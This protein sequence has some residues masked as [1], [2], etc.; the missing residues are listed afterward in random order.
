M[1]KSHKSRGKTFKVYSPVV[2]T[3]IRSGYLYKSPP[4]KRFK[5]EKSWKNRYF[6]LFKV[7]SN[8][9]Q[10]KYFKSADEKE[11]PLGEIDLEQISLL[12]VNPVQHQRWEWIQKNFMCSP[13]C[14]L[15]ISA[16]GRDYFLVGGNSDEVDG[17]F[18]DLYDALKNRPHKFGPEVR[19]NGQQTAEVISKPLVQKYN[20]AIVFEK[21][22]PKIRSASDPLSNCLDNT[23]KSKSEGCSRRPLSEPIYDYPRS[24]L[25]Q[26]QVEEQGSTCAETEDTLYE[27]MNKLSHDEDREVEEVTYRSVMSLT[28]HFEKLKMPPPLFREETESDDRDDT[29]PSDVSSSSSSEN[30][31]ISLGE[32]LEGRNVSSLEKQSSTQRLDHIIPEEIDI[33]IKQAHL[34]K[35]LTL[36]EVDGK[37]GVSGW[38]GQP[39]CLFHRGDQVLAINDLQIGSVTEFST[40][41]SK[42]LKNEVKLTI[43]RLPGCLP[44]HS[45]TCLCSR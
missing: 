21:Q 45:P 19:H 36:T 12:N 43:L 41:I 10:L 11:K 39:V 28:K 2:V 26:K 20:A 37:P 30:G 35:H 44:L 4:S 1:H 3:Q 6:V 14:V 42:S 27:T 32:M 15:Y 22:S 16:A 34:K 23:D 5:S 29:H 40:Y 18:F 31:D 33:E 24:D 7:S 13:S 9:H 17:W 8:E 25:C 38:T